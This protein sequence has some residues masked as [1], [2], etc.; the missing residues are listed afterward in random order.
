MLAGG[1]ARP[2]KR[3][4]FAVVLLKAVASALEEIPELS[5]F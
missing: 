3:V 1:I 2:P 5:G 4:L